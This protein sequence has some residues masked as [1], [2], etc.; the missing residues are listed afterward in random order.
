[1]VRNRQYSCECRQH[2]VYGCRRQHK[3][4]TDDTWIADAG[5]ICHITNNLEGMLDIKSICESVKIGTGEDTYATKC[6]K[7]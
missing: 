4:L 5:A 1:M 3:K 2:G 7:F 6:E